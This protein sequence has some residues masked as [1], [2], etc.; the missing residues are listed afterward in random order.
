M[1]VETSDDSV[2]SPGVMQVV[3]TLQPGG[4]ERL[5]IE[6]AR[7]VS[8]V[9]PSVV[10]CLEEAGA[11]AE[12]LK[13]AGIEVVALQ[14]KP[15]FRPSLGARIARI[16]M[17]RG[18]GVLHCHQYTPFVYGRIAVMHRRQLRLVYTEHGRLSDAR[19]STKRRL[20]NPLL[21]IGSAPLIAV[22]KDLR[23]YLIESGFP[24]DRVTVVY[25]GIDPGATPSMTERVY[26][27]QTLGI[28]PDAFVAGT[29]ARLA[30]VKDVPVLLDAFA[31]LSREVGHAWLLVVGDGSERPALERQVR[32][33]GCSHRVTFAGH[34]DDARRLLP[35]LDV[36]VNCSI[37]EGMSV[38]ILEAMSAAVC[39]VATRV[40][41]N[42]EL[43][44]DGVTGVL[45]PARSPGALAGALAHLA[46]SPEA[47]V[48]MGAAGRHKVEASFS[49]DRMVAEY[50]RTYGLGGEA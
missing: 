20:V 21:S 30:P 42:P 40:G 12:Q 36:F 49:L 41:G 4:T 19:P 50:L 35:A 32:D 45:I 28:P 15:G 18:I 3:L 10:C 37:T 14:R 34:R 46:L 24:S 31:A 39:V 38:T 29:V 27:R 13:A 25:N 33:L 26:V 43:V 1:S 2:R 5:V 11:W 8:A 47:R 48:A 17:Q 9:T 6:L 16:S 44:G 22:S 23:R 7:R